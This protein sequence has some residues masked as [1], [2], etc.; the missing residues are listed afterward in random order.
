[1]ENKKILKIKDAF[2]KIPIAL[3]LIILALLVLIPVVW[4][5]FSAFKPE[6]EIISWPPTF[7]PKS[8]TLENFTDV[9]NRIDIIKYIA[10]SV[11]YAGGTTALAV[12]V[13]SMAGYAYAFYDFKGKNGAFIM[14]LATMMVPFQVIMVPLFLVVYKMGMYDSYWGLIIPRVAVA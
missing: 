6:K 12:V 5:V 9:Q 7:I 8:L 3:V 2:F 1:M 4:M 13:N 10:N 11:I 14:T